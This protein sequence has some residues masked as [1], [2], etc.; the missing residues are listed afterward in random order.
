MKNSIV[1]NQLSKKFSDELVLD[2]ITVS[3]EAGKIYG[4]IGKNGSGKTVLF[5]CIAGFLRPTKG[6]VMVKEKRIGIDSD[7]PEDIGLMIETPGFLTQYTGIY[8][9]KYLASI[10][11][12]IS[13]K[14][15]KEAM[16]QVGL[17][18]DN[19]KRVGKYSLGMR[20][21]LGIAQA[22]MEKPDILILDEPMN[23]LDKEGIAQMRRLFLNFKKQGKTLVFASHN[24]EDIETLCDEVYEMD[25]GVLKP[26]LKKN[27]EM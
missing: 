26:Y 6:S 8:N 27:E 5:K 7:F 16:I 11:N 17:E 4:I 25:H 22:I 18:P 3:F 2:N 15:I 10:R 14:E 13:E 23:G 19:K 1:I 9:L 20:Q 24:R 12:R 21:R